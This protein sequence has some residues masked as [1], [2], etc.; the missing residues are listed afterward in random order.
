MERASEKSVSQKMVS[1]TTRKGRRI[2]GNSSLLVSVVFNPF[3][4]M[5]PYLIHYLPAR[6]GL[7]T[8]NKKKTLWYKIVKFWK[9]EK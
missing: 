5:H 4:E 2:V 7:P 1:P 9:E 6:L 8:R 3:I